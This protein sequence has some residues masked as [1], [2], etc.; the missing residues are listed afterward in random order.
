[1]KPKERVLVMFD[2]PSKTTL[3]QDFSE[4]FKTEDWA[5]ERDVVRALSKLGLDYDCLG[6]YND[7]DLI[8]Q[9]IKQVKPDVIFNLVERFN[10]NKGL[11]NDI[12]SYLLLLGVPFTGCS[13]TGLAFSKNKALSK[14]ILHFHRIRVPQFTILPRG[15]K[16]IRP[17]KLAFPIFIKP[18][19]EEASLGISQAS[20]VETDEQFVQRA[21]FIHNNMEQDAIAEEYIEGRELYVSLIGNTRFQVFPVREIVFGQVPDDE[22]KFASYKAKW[23]KAYRKRWGIRNQFANTLPNG[24]GERIKTLGKKIC[25]LLHINGY[26][27]LDMRLTPAGELVFIEANPNPM[28]AKEED[29]AESAIKAGMDY[30][31]LIRKIISLGK[32][33]HYRWVDQY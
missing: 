11:D 27:R 3:D 8:S 32:E 29:F 33:M 25:K 28:L 19:K 17:K 6:V 30:P 18:L 1:M 16:I 15:K 5:T 21:E 13:P 22:P 10:G 12:A 4:E 9:K 2:A 24:T 26:C 14:E 20:F 7:T 31:H 23:D